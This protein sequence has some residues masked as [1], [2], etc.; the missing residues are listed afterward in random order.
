MPSV[1][2]SY[3]KSDHLFAELV[4]GKFEEAE[5]ELW[6]D[7]HELLAG[8]DWER[9]IESA[10]EACDVVIVALS[11]N[12]ANSGYVTYEW[13]YALGQG[14]QVIPMKIDECDVHPRLEKTQNLDF[15][16]HRDYPWEILFERVKQIAKAKV[17]TTET[18]TP[19]T[20]LQQILYYLN[21]NGF[22]MASFERL[23]KHTSGNLQDQ[24]F[25]DIISQNPTTLRK[26]RLKGNKLGVARLE[27]F[28]HS[29]T[30]D[31]S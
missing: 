23:K 18:G 29:V 17:Q 1:F 20:P 31:Q 27:T 4:A 28:E 5:I 15:T 10:L 21:K 6:R 30:P 25:E 26:A 2:L 22:R 24:D 3:S 12:S 14:K 13:A 7:T 9:T 16:R 19:D 11:P 8:T